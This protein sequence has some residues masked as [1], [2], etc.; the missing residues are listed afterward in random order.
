MRLEGANS[1]TEKQPDNERQEVRQDVKE[2]IVR[3]L[4]EIGK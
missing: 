2:K 3:R 4:S 1:D